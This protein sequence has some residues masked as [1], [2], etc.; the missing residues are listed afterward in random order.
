MRRITLEKG[1]LVLVEDE[2]LGF[3]ERRVTPFGNSAKV[4]CP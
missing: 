1:K 2:V 3:L 4:D